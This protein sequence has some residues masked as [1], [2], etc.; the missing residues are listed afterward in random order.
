MSQ[1]SADEIFQFAI[2]IEENGK[3]FYTDMAKKFSKNEKISNLFKD[4][5]NQEVEHGNMF[6][7]MLKKFQDY[8]PS[9]SY[10]EEYFTYLRAYAENAI[11]S[12]EALKRE[13]EKITDLESAL[14]FAIK[15]ELESIHYYNELKNLVSSEDIKNIEQIIEEERKHFSY[16]NK[17]KRELV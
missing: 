4:L 3:N 8:S 13:K 17:T 16:L 2:K 12:D 7:S 1:Y 10:P 9:E 5:S 14:N 6:S 11:F 15:R